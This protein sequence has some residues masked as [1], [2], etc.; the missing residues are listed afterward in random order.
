M[1]RRCAIGVFLLLTSPAAW[2]QT[3]AGDTAAAVA[4]AESA[5]PDAAAAIAKLEASV[6]T[7]RP[8]DVA[9]VD[10]IMKAI[11]ASIS[12]PAGNRSLDRFRSLM[13]PAAR[14]TDSIID[15]H[16][17][18]AVEQWSVDQFIAEAQPI[19]AKDPFYE[20]GLVNRVQRFGNIA[21]VF[22]SY[23]S[24]SDPKGEPFQR[25]I[26]SMQLMFDGKRWWVVSIL[27]DTE[28]PGNA[29]PKAMQR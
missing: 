20:Q 7:P 8:S 9:S 16:G 23:A 26:N 15:E 17:K 18:L 13:L 19:F 22:S 6:P 3:P 14:L 10:G 29:L 21:Q 25:G 4:K 1:G 11:Y 28:R 5:P 12:G 27:W 2:V 24:R